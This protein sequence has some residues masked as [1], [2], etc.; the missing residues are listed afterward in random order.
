MQNVILFCEEVLLKSIFELF[1]PNIFDHVVLAK[2]Q[3]TLGKLK[4]LHLCHL[5]ETTEFLCLIYLEGS[6]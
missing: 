3:Q 5:F 4:L 2:K 1:F 6:N